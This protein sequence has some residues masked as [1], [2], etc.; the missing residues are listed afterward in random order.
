LVVVFVLRGRSERKLNMPPPVVSSSPYKDTPDPTNRQAPSYSD[1]IPT[2]L[3][4]GSF[5]SQLQTDTYNL[6]IES[7][8]GQTRYVVNG[9]AYN[10]L[11]EIPDAD[12]R[13]VA[14]KLYDKTFQSGPVEQGNQEVLRQVMIGNQTTIESKSGDTNLSIQ[15]QGQ[16]TRFIVNGMTYYHLNDIPDPDMRHKAKELLSQML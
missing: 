3:T 11:D 8:K 14:Q 1:L 15:K 4:Q 6:R 9:V 13:S 12:M 10:S 2:D 7:A 5:S 16:Q